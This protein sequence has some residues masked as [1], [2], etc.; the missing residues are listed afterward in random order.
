MGGGEITANPSSAL[1]I[2]L[3]RAV[4]PNWGNLGSPQ[5]TSGAAGGSLGGDGCKGALLPLGGR[6]LSTAAARCPRVH[7][8]PPTVRK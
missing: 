4:I 1:E 5:G 2:K 3:S 8:T 6:G 7:R